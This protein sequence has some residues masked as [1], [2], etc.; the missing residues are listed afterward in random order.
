MEVVLVNDEDKRRYLA[1][2]EELKHQGESFFPYTV[3]KDALFALLVFLILMALA[4]FVGAPLE[5]RADPTNTAYVPRPEWYFMFLFDLL[6]YFPG[7]LEW[8][9]V[10]VLPGAALAFLFFLPLLDRGPVRHPSQR[11]VT[12]AI[13]SLAVVGVVLLTLQAYQVN[14]SNL[15]AQAAQLLHF[16]G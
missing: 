13:T 4:V 5:A 2:Y 1:R 10:A 7:S 15:M 8:V 6:K 11:P 16:H 3:A 12:V 14:P 9:G